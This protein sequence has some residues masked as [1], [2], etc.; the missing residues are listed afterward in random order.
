M[1][2]TTVRGTP[3]YHEIHGAGEPVLLLHGG[4]C[5]IEMMRPQLEALSGDYTVYA[6][7]RPGHGRSPDRAGPMGYAESVADTIAYLDEV[8]LADAHIVGF[9]DGAI[10]GLL[11]ALQ[12]PRRIRSLVSISGNLDPAGFVASSGE[13]EKNEGADVAADPDRA[14]QW[15]DE[16][17][18]DGPE[19]ADV[20]MEKLTRL[21]TTEPAIAPADLARVESPTL[22]MAGDHDVIRL[23]HS[24]L[25]AESI[26]GAQLCIVPGAGHGL[27]DERPGFVTFAV[28]EFLAGLRA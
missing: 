14:R 24:A 11:V 1:T 23:D 2:M 6:P 18:P 26:P 3:I 28:R 17:S 8:G 4:F 21:W 19:H 12:H 27:L 5:S 10:I 7:E 25:M 13:A 15:Y 9:S 16:L 20:V 22:I